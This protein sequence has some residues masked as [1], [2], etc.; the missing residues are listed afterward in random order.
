MLLRAHYLFQFIKKIA[1]APVFFEILSFKDMLFCQTKII[2]FVDLVPL[3]FLREA[4][5][6]YD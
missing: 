4:P 2:S 1:E 3:P 6:K 5:L